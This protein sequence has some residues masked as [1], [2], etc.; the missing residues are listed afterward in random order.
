MVDEKINPPDS[1]GGWKLNSNVSTHAAARVT[2]N[3][4]GA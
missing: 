1:P 2:N 3:T 4:L